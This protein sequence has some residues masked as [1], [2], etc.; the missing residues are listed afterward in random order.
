[1]TCCWTSKQG[2]S[3]NWSLH[4]VHTHCAKIAFLS[5]C[6]VLCCFPNKPHIVQ[7]SS[8]PAGLIMTRKLRSNSS[9]SSLLSL[10]KYRWIWL[11]TYFLS[12]ACIYANIFGVGKC[13]ATASGTTVQRS[14]RL[15]NI[16]ALLTFYCTRFSA[17]LHFNIIWCRA[18]PGVA[19][20][21]FCGVRLLMGLCSERDEVEGSALSVINESIDST[22][23]AALINSRFAARQISLMGWYKARC[24]QD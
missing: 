17:V 12:V 23:S 18:T 6:T 7:L 9:I 1:M 24:S 11:A 14:V 10:L 19:R 8:R 3:V 22:I 5:T 16:P 21:S 13:P 15:V 2:W 20:R 4:N